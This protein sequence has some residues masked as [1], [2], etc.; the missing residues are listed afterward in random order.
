MQTEASETENRIVGILSPVVRTIFGANSKGEPEFLG[1]GII[2]RHNADYFLITAAHVIDRLDSMP[3]FIDGENH[4]VQLSGEL[5]ATPMPS[6]GRRCD[7]KLDIAVIRLENNTVTQL[8]DVKTIGIN[9]LET[10]SSHNQNNG[11]VAIGYPISKQQK[12]MCHDKKEISPFLYGIFGHEAPMDAYDRVGVDRKSHL[13]ISLKTKRVY[14]SLGEVRTAP[15]LNGM[16]GTGIWG[17]DNN[18]NAKLVAIL[19][20]YHKPKGS[21]V[22]VRSICTIPYISEL[23]KTQNGTPSFT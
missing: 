4:L 1:C 8:E 7:D 14:G 12:S 21:L 13:V 22:G 5:L 18:G 10:N 19:I 16:S 11:Y 15:A 20:E 3:L 2:L 23:M 17:I 9:S 6:S